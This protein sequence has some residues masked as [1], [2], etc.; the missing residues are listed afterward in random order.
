MEK[1]NVYVIGI[2][3]AVVIGGGSFF[4]GTK[5]GA[6][7][8]ATSKAALSAQRGAGGGAG[9]RGGM[10]GGAGAGFVSGKILSKDATSLTVQLQ[11]NSS[12]IVYFSSSTSVG[13][14]TTGTVDDLSV[15]T[16]V[17]VTGD[18]T[19]DGIV[20]AKTI[21]VRPEHPAGAQNSAPNQ[22]PAQQ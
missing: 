18:A 8:A 15:G 20:T 9:R 22:P 13:R 12:K 2:I 6:S 16:N 1:N 4:A 5:Y 17:T 10:A 3:L 19:L 7:S 21:Q 11:D 14:M